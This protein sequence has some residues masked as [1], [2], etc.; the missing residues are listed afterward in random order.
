MEAKRNRDVN[1]RRTKSPIFGLSSATIEKFAMEFVGFSP[2]LGKLKFKSGMQLTGRNYLLRLPDKRRFNVARMQF[3]RLPSR[4]RTYS[5]SSTK[6]SHKTFQWPRTVF[7]GLLYSISMYAENWLM[8]SETLLSS[9]SELY[10]VRD[11]SL[12]SNSPTE[13]PKW[14]PRP[15]LPGSLRTTFM[16]SCQNSRLDADWN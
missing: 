7:V 13:D 3:A 14:K 2:N 8:A 15:V 12:I 10:V 9:L 5:N 11:V 16:F 1:L 4:L 6:K